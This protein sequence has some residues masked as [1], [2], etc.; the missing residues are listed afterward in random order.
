VKIGG[1][2]RRVVLDYAALEPFRAAAR[3]LLQKIGEGV[4]PR[5]EV[6]VEGR[7]LAQARDLHIAKMRNQGKAA[8]SIAEYELA[9]RHLS[10]WLG[11]PLRRV[12]PEMA[13][14]RHQK[15]G[16]KVGPYAANKTMRGLRAFWNT[17]RREDLSLGESPTIAVAWYKEKRRKAAIPLASLPKWFGSLS[18]IRNEVKRDLLLLTILT[19]LRKATVCT[20]RR[21]AVD[22]ELGTLHIPRPKGGE[23]RAFTIPLSD[24]A[25]A[26]CARRLAATNSEWL[27]PSAASNSGHIEDPRVEPSDFDVPFTPHGLR[28]TYISAGHAAGVS[29]RHAQLLVNHAVHD[30]DVHGGYILA[31]ID[32]LRPSQQRITDYFKEHG[33]ALSLAGPE[34]SRVTSR[35]KA[36]DRT[37]KLL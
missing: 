6:G 5:S 22:L 24:A 23:D 12:K 20:I 18:K 15:I 28:A 21:E 1:R 4:D 2:E 29:D 32:A 10:D 33:L 36:A 9:A 37:R 31:D 35:R 8:A 3:S 26:V 14:E 19:G 27:F 7:T 25:L 13:R 30:S 16:K 34:K 17:A 11:V